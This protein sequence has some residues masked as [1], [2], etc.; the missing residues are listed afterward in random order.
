[1]RRGAWESIIWERSPMKG[2]RQKTFF[3]AEGSLPPMRA[4]DRQTRAGKAFQTKGTVRNMWRWEHKRQTLNI[5]GQAPELKR[6]RLACRHLG[7][8][9]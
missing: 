8:R 9:R 7:V 6:L 1:M 4:S 2:E 5:R 3:L